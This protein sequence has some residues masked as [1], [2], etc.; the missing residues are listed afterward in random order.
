MEIS[1]TMWDEGFTVTN[2]LEA[3]QLIKALQESEKDLKRLT[4]NIK[5]EI[6]LLEAMGTEMNDKHSRLESRI[7]FLLERYVA[8]EVLKE[9]LKETATQMKYSLARGDIVVKKAI[10][11]LVKPDE[12]V[13]DS[14]IGLY[15]E[16]VKE[17]KTF[18]WGDFKKNIKITEEGKAVNKKTNKVIEGIQVVEE[19]PETAIKYKF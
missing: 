14:L 18:N 13:E 5:Q 6:Q 15:P 2:D 3:G 1:M 7:K 12:A 16:F 8:E 10:N 19:K 4:D 9:D 11:K 17:K